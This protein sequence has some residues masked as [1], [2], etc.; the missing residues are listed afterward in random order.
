MINVLR[1]DAML[2]TLGYEETTLTTQSWL[3][4][5]KNNL[6]GFIRKGNIEHTFC[7]QRNM[8]AKCQ[9]EKTIKNQYPFSSY[10]KSSNNGYF[11]L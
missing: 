7:F 2:K 9:I 10:Y 8:K 6:I 4:C 3:Y 5:L 11:T 1:E